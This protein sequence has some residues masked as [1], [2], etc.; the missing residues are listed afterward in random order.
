MQKS[1]LDATT[2]PNAL[3]TQSQW[4][5]EDDNVEVRTLGYTKNLISEGKASWDLPKPIE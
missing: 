5:D 3:M 1:N 4:K 2:L